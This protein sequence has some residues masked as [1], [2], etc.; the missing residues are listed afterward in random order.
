MGRRKKT[1]GAM[2][3]GPY[4][5]HFCGRTL[6]SKYTQEALRWEWFTGYG[7]SPLHFCPPCRRAR[8][9]DIDR[10]REKLNVKPVGYPEV[11]A[12]L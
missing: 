7:E 5:C 12:K 6:E 10:L 1:D 8:Q 11:R 9:F 4:P 3:P 2:Y